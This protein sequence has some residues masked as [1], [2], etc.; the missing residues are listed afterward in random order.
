MD[1]GN[2]PYVVP[3]KTEKKK[4]ERTNK[5]KYSE[6]LNAEA[7]HSLHSIIRSP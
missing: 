6:A 4:K 2:A 3:H 7:A 5:Q 1:H